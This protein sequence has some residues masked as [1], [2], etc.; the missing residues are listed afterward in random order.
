MCLN[1]IKDHETYHY[2]LD[3]PLK[4]APMC[5]TK[6]RGT[7]KTQEFECIFLVLFYQLQCLEFGGL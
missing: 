6:Q 7:S 5:F 2:Y 4:L 1:H 3:L